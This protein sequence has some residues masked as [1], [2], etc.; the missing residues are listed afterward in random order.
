MSAEERFEKISAAFRTRTQMA[1][2]QL[3]QAQAAVAIHEEEMQEEDDPTEEEFTI[4]Q[5]NDLDLPDAEANQH[6][7]DTSN[8]PAPEEN[9]NNWI[10]SEEG[11]LT[12]YYNT[13][14][15]D[16]QNLDPIPYNNER[17]SRSSYGTNLSRMIL[18][19]ILLQ[20]EGTPACSKSQSKGVTF[21]HHS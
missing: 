9:A 12:F 11:F 17:R 6:D 18:A 19:W 20:F 1:K 13:A 16:D 14:H 4:E 5:N 21:Q 8:E 10:I 3:D 7:Q 15:G 2:R